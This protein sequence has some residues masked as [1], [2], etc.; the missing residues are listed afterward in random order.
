MLPRGPKV[1]PKWTQNGPLE[2]PG[3]PMWTQNPILLYWD[4]FWSPIWSPKGS[5]NRPKIDSLREKCSKERAFKAVFAWRAA[6]PQFFKLLLVF[7]GQKT[8][9]KS[10]CSCTSCWCFP[11]LKNHAFYRLPCL[12]TV[13]LEICRNREKQAKKRGNAMKN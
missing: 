11:P 2:R 9:K 5:Q 3:A 1:T 4:R 8:M 13:F 7:F 12:G 10:S 6:S